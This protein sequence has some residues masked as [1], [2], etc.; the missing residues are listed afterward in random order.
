MAR[1]TTRVYAHRRTSRK[2]L[3]GWRK[4][5]RTGRYYRDVPSHMIYS[6]RES[7]RYQQLIRE[8]VTKE[9]AEKLAYDKKPISRIQTPAKTVAQEVEKYQKEGYAKHEAQ[10]LAQTG[11]QLQQSISPSLART[12]L[13]PYREAGMS[14]QGG[15]AVSPSYAQKQT[16]A[17]R[18]QRVVERGEAVREGFLDVAKRGAEPSKVETALQ[19]QAPITQRIGT[20]IVSAFE[21]ATGW[22]SR[23]AKQ[24]LPSVSRTSQARRILAWSKETPYL[25]GAGK[26]TLQFGL[27]MGETFYTSMR[28]KPIRAGLS[29]AGG[30]GTGVLFKGVGAAV[31]TGKIGKTISK[32]KAFQY[33]KKGVTTV[34]LGAYAGLKGYEISKAPTPFEKGGVVG[35]S[36]FEEAIPFSL[37]MGF[38]KWWAKGS[39]VKPTT[40]YTYKKPQVTRKKDLPYPL[41]VDESKY[42][43]GVERGIER[44]VKREAR[45]RRIDWEGLTP[46]TKKWVMGQTRLRYERGEFLPK[47]TQ[48]AIKRAKIRSKAETT[49]LRRLEQARKPFEQKVI[50]GLSPADIRWRVSQAKIKA[51]ERDLLGLRKFE[52]KQRAE[53]TRIR[54]LEQARKPFEQKVIEGL[55]PATRKFVTGQAKIRARERDVTQLALKRFETKKLADV[56]RAK[57]LEQVR[58]PFELPVRDIRI[59]KLP[60]R[61]VRTFKFEEPKV[62][63][64]A[65]VTQEGLIKV[66]KTKIT[67]PKLRQ[68]KPVTLK[69]KAIPLEWK[70]VYDIP[71]PV[72]SLKFQTQR[73]AYAPPRLLT[74]STLKQKVKVTPA[75]AFFPA[76]KEAYKVPSK[77]VSLPTFKQPQE[78]GQPQAFKQY[79]EFGQPQE[80]LY[81]PTQEFPFPEPIKPM[82]EQPQQQKEKVLPILGFQTAKARVP[83]TL[84]SFDD[85]EPK[86]VK[87]KKIKMPQPVKYVPTYFAASLKIKAP[88]IRVGEVKTGLGVRGYVK[89]KEL[90]KVP[91]FNK[92]GGRIR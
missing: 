42:L 56:T 88:K 36:L 84:P 43:R 82:Y 4:E 14:V 8:G 37:G 76:V 11:H 80:Q 2:H 23:K 31:R 33:A 59:S 85:I 73:S 62:P 52:A 55:T 6:Q 10:I 49:R 21:K 3:R 70:G 77:V 67:K 16:E 50:E 5:A 51:R 74:R 46:A 39:K 9:Q 89:G 29:F 1:R 20:P 45:T 60:K 58:K 78:F 19:Y 26:S 17:L 53:T 66:Q 65:I 7:R 69:S 44:T 40:K 34:S 64:G 18:Q 87:K 86:K 35:R 22:T 83:F 41:K 47:P 28:E 12:I 30:V 68:E 90:V 38:T 63:K 91:S 61:T 15:Y 27:G 24:I 32:A 92:F 13:T 79:Q 54:R 71:E 75:L 25:T 57:R 48:L 72:E 81:E